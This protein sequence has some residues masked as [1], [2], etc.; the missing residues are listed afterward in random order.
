MKKTLT[1]STAH[2]DATRRNLLRKLRASAT[3]AGLLGLNLLKPLKT[4]AADWEE[5]A[6]SAKNFT[7]ALNIHGSLISQESSDIKIV[8]PELAENGSQVVVD[9]ASMIAH[10]QNI[11]IFIEKNP[12]PLAASFSYANGALPKVRLPL[13][14][15]ETTRLRAVVKTSEGKNYHAQRTIQVTLGGCAT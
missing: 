9:I 3:I 7:E 5:R 11:A 10:T 8:A 1:T 2:I 14:L 15:S 4:W 12:R 6:F 13:R